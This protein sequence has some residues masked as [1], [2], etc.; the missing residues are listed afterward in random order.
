MSLQNN[1]LFYILGLYN[2][3]D[4]MDHIT[5]IP[6]YIPARLELVQQIQRKLPFKKEQSKIIARDMYK[7]RPNTRYQ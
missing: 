4:P 2:R 5:Y 1:I 6:I 7:A 3:N